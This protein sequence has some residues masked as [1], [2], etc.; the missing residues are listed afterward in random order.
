M[1]EDLV[2]TAFIWNLTV[3]SYIEIHGMSLLNRE[4]KLK[5]RFQSEISIHVCT[6]MCLPLEKRWQWEVEN[7]NIGETLQIFNPT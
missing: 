5:N 3:A 4:G 2:G 1:N 7:I 6:F